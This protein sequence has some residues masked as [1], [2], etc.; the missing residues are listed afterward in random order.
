MPSLHRN[1]MHIFFLSRV[2]DL[3]YRWDMTIVLETLK[4]ADAERKLCEMALSSCGSIVD[5]AELLGITRHALKR[6][7]VKHKIRCA[8]PSTGANLDSA[9][10]SQRPAS[11][12]ASPT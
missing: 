10:M 9:P 4:L 11:L 12:S 1:F 8:S 3:A 2:P 6:R 7:M 5:A